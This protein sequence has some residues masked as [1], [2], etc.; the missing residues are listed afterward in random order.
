VVGLVLI[1]TILLFTQLFLLSPV[2]ATAEHQS[3]IML[4]QPAPTT[5]PTTQTAN[6]I[7]LPLVAHESDNELDLHHESA[8]PLVMASSDHT[9]HSTTP[10]PDRK[11]LHIYC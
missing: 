5:L 9:G 6:S 1:G 11:Q 7:F 2:K 8:P 4:A 10:P 3:E